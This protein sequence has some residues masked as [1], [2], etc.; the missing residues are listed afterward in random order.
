M[1]IVNFHHVFRRGNLVVRLFRE[2]SSS[3]TIQICRNGRC[4]EADV[5]PRELVKALSM[6]AADILGQ[7]FVDLREAARDSL[8]TQ[9]LVDR[10]LLQRR[11]EEREE[12]GES[13]Y[14]RYTVGLAAKL[15][16]HWHVYL[17]LED[18]LAE[19]KE[20]ND[21]ELCGDGE[22]CIE[23]ALEVA[24]LIEERLNVPRNVRLTVFMRR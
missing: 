2:D 15:V 4:I 11:L 9:L 5:D 21:E 22:K 19:L 14:D 16:K 13:D 10:A 23:N 24:R 12:R 20:R 8:W 17:S 7:T 6:M 18:L 1:V 3:V